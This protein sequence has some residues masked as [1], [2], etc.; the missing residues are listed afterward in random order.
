[1]SPIWFWE[2][3]KWDLKLVK[4]PNSLQNSNRS[5]R[6]QTFENHL[7][8]CDRARDSRKNSAISGYGFGHFID[9]RHFLKTADSCA[10]NPCVSTNCNFAAS[11]SFSLYIR[12]LTK[13]TELKNSRFIYV[14]NENS[15][16]AAMNQKCRAFLYCNSIF[17]ISKIKF[18]GTVQQ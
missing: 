8:L 2:F 17:L 5:S 13:K 18:L 3:Y 11:Y 14:Q 12:S 16:E 15:L 1:M 9:E 4:E 7:R 6:S 10:L